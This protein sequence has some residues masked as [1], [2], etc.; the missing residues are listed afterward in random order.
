MSRQVNIGVSVDSSKAVSNI[1]TL[2][3]AFQ[4]LNE[5]IEKNGKDGSLKIR[6]NLEGIDVKTFEG[7][8]KNFSKISKSIDT[9]ENS[10]S[11]MSSNSKNL[12]I[13]ITSISNITNRARDNTDKYSS[14]V[15]K[16]S[17]QQ[18]GF[19]TS[20]L[21]GIVQL[22]ALRRGFSYL[23]SDY[24][25]LMDKTFSVGIAGEMNIE[26]IN[27]LNESFAKLSTTVPKSA[28]ELATAV[29]DLI[30]TGRSY[31]ESRKIIEEVARLSVASGDDLK[32]TAQVVTKVMVSL[33]VNADRTV[34]T[35]NSMHSTAIQ[36]ASDMG[37][38]AEAYKNI[39]GTNAVFVASTGLAGEALD[40]YKQKVLDLSM[41]SIGHMANLGLSASQT[42]TKIKQMFGRLVSAET[43]AKKMFNQEMILNNVQI[44]GELF[45]YDKLSQMAKTDLPKAVETMS[46][47]YIQGKLSS[48]VLQKLFT[49]RHFMELS[50]LLLAVNGNVDGFVD[51]ITKGANYSEDVYKSMFN[52]NRQTEL[53]QNNIKTAFQP[54]SESGASSVTGFFMGLN[55]LLTKMNTKEE[56]KFGKNIKEFMNE[57]VISSGLS[58]ASIVALGGALTFLKPIVLA[59]GTAFSGLLTS[60][61]IAGVSNPV[62]LL[63][64][65][66]GGLFYVLQKLGKQA[67]E[68]K[69]KIADFFTTISSVEPNIDSVSNSVDTL[70]TSMN[71]LANSLEKTS[72]INI[73]EY[74][75]NNYSAIDVLAEKYKDYYDTVD[76]L[77]TLDPL[78]TELLTPRIKEMENRLSSLTN[79]VSNYRKELEKLQNIDFKD[80]VLGM[81]DAQLFY[82]KNILPADER[83]N[84]L[85]EFYSYILQE[86]KQIENP[87][88]LMKNIYKAGIEKYGFKSNKD[89]DWFL[90]NID[91]K[92]YDELNQK[93]NETAKYEKELREE[94]ENTTRAI[95]ERVKLAEQTQDK[96]ASLVNKEQSEFFFETGQIILSDGR[97]LKGEDAILHELKKGLPNVIQSIQGD[98]QEEIKLYEDEVRRLYEDTSIE[99]FMQNTERIQKLIDR[100]NT[101]RIAENNLIKAGQRKII[102]ILDNDTLMW[103]RGLDIKPNMVADV[104]QYGHNKLRQNILKE[105]GG[106]EQQVEGLDEYGKIRKARISHT[107][108]TNKSKAKKK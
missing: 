25:S 68:D 37:Y 103:F 89:V 17:R 59:T 94:Y 9:L 84:Q 102:E 93:I 43:V 28:Q 3:K 63:I 78:D 70:R 72:N 97:T 31:D 54:I 32:S 22:E 108:A 99:N 21:N 7:L 13:N 24:L 52:L 44:G 4:E 56:G 87:E 83:S 69:R 20:V 10:F 77:E 41:A 62:G 81:G 107:D 74:I 67:L 39:A 106:H 85:K 53:L 48:Q 34:E 47:L 88:D 64:V 33:G 92:K 6:V 23:K 82:F 80:L 45:N 60:M 57:L 98:I 40:D 58:I 101:L 90:K 46:K 15:K 61:G 51:K 65:A 86:Q 35:L 95:N 73:A 16:A 71:M 66:L 26:Q 49:A 18:E 36:T 11:K 30:R 29:D 38:L 79:E 76:S 105:I 42:G 27:A 12:G 75:K 5:A 14:S 55:E 96:W 104:L 19:N 91:T 100:I 50:D 8:A 2:K 1:N